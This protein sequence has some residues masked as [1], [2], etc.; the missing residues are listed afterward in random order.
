MLVNCKHN[1]SIFKFIILVVD[2]NI[3]K[4]KIELGNCLKCDLII[5]KIEQETMIIRGSQRT[6][7]FSLGNPCTTW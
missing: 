7:L 5:M 2:L 6:I 4:N 3:K 1:K